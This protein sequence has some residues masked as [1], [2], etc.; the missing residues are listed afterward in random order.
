MGEFKQTMIES[1]LDGDDG[2]TKVHNLGACCVIK[3][4]DGDDIH[5]I[6]LTKRDVKKIVKAL[7]IVIERP[8][9]SEVVEAHHINSV[10]QEALEHIA[11]DTEENRQQIAQETLEAIAIRTNK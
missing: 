2:W 6:A 4:F 7:N 1:S 3:Q 10:L 11:S 5:S 9:H 8:H